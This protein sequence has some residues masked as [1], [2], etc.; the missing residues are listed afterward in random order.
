MSILRWLAALLA[1]RPDTVSVATRVFWVGRR[2]L[3]RPTY[4]D[5]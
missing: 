4:Y 5:D 3:A 2:N 1:R